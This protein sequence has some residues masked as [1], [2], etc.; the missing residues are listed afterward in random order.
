MCG[1]CLKELKSLQVQATS[2]PSCRSIRHVSYAANEHARNIKLW[3]MLTLAVAGTVQR[4]LAGG[5]RGLVAE[6]ASDLDIDLSPN[7]G[8]LSATIRSGD[9][10][11]VNV[12]VR[13]TWRPG[14]TTRVRTTILRLQCKKYI[15]ICIHFHRNH[16]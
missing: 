14:G 12:R 16:S 2:D 10:D 6:A 11:S 8:A 9:H 1:I 7:G 4:V 15:I 3:L 13:R 5:H